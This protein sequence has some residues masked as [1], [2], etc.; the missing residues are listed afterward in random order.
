MAI[1]LIRWVLK[2]WDGKLG[3]LICVVMISSSMVLGQEDPKPNIF[4]FLSDD[5]GAADVRA[6]G[7]PDVFTPVLDNWKM[8]GVVFTR[9]YAPASVCAPSRSALFTGLYPHRNGCDR[10]HGSI[11]KGIKT[12]PDYL[13]PL[14]YRILLAGKKHIAPEDQFDFEYLDLEAVPTLLERG[15]DEPFCLIVS[16]HAPHQ[17]YF[18]HK[19]GSTQI[20]PKTWMP[21]TEKTRHYTAAYYDHVQILDNELGAYQFWIEKY[22]YGD[23]VQ[24]Y[25]SDH[26]PAFPFAKWSLYENGIRIPLMIKWP[27]HI[28]PGTVQNSLVSMVDIL[29]TLMDL[30]GEKAP[31]PESLDGQSLIPLLNGTLPRIRT[32]VYA[33]YT[34]LG[35]NGANEYPIRTILSGDWK[36]LVNLKAHHKFHIAR[37]D[38][39]DDRAV[40][41][42]YDVLQSWLNHDSD[43]V[44]QRAEYHWKRPAIELYHL[45]EDPDELINLANRKDFAGILDAMMTELKSWMD[46]QG[47]PMSP[48]FEDLFTELKMRSE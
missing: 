15:I 19:G 29:P 2:K 46:A 23:A 1:N 21:D 7:N 44:R 8:E 18:N 14:G 33:T 9:A 42:S 25:L 35:V 26:G 47:D 11:R 45:A 43:V 13:K 39:P 38:Q 22:G 6:L 48:D 41:D 16:L 24:I 30:A 4:I 37:M 40:I 34:N 36:L 28:S 10:N 5:H 3:K 31:A 20:T 32:H 12:L 17:P 27:G